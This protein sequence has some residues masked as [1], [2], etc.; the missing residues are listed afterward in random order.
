MFWTGFIIG[1]L[2]VGALVWLLVA[3]DRTRPGSSALTWAVGGVWFLYTAGVIATSLTFVAEG[4]PKAAAVFALCFGAIALLGFVGVRFLA[5]KQT[6]ACG[7]PAPR[8][9]AAQK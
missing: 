5:R 8:A 3:R 9:T 7:G 2:V 6:A 1:A 4:E